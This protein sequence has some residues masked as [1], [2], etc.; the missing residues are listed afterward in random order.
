M[1]D[2]SSVLSHKKISRTTSANNVLEVMI[3]CGPKFKKQ[4]PI[5]FSRS[6]RKHLV[7]P[8]ICLRTS[9]Q[10]YAFMWIDENSLF[11]LYTTTK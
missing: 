8:F 4:L 5:S 11:Q 7:T 3:H 1:C 6:E 2:T 9:N 10:R